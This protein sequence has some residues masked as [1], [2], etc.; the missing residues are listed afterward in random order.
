[1]GGYGALKLGLRCPERFAAVAG[2]SSVTDIKYRFRAD[3]SAAW[4]PELRRIF[5]STS[6]L[7]DR[8]NDLFDL[9]VKARESGKELPEILSICGSEDFMIMDNRKFNRHMRKIEYPGFY[10]F[11]RPGTHNWE[12]WDRHIQD[13]LKFFTTG[14]LPE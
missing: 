4:R 8:G 6:Q 10:S 13:A 2:L 14:E 11:E 3:T 9:A 5:G 7:K 12:F 1:M